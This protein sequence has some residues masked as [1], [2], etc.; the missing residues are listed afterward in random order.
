MRATQLMLRGFSVLFGRSVVVPSRQ[1][2]RE[3]LSDPALQELWS[4]L[5]RTYFP[6]VT[7]LSTY[8]IVWS[9]RRQKRVLGSCCVRKRRISLAQELS[10][11]EYGKYL[12]A[13][14]YHEMCHAVLEEKVER[15]GSKRCWH[16]GAFKSL[17]QRHPHVEELRLWMRTGGW[18]K[19]VRQH[20]GRQKRR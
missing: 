4:F 6:E 19:A 13:V 15:R 16:G 20:R 3:Q 9:R 10:P 5:H 2:D 11:P 1:P 17:E 18:A 14:V 8:Q 7:H 12:E